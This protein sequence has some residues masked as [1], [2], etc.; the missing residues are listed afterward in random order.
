VWRQEGVASLWKGN[1]ATI[2]HRVP[3][4]A[5]NFAVFEAT[6]EALE[7]HM[8]SDI[9]R[10]LVAGGSAGLVACTAVSRYYPHALGLPPPSPSL[11]HILAKHVMPSNL[12]YRPTQLATGPD[13]QQP[14][15]A[16]AASSLP[17]S[18]PQQLPAADLTATLHVGPGTLGSLLCASAAGFCTSTVTFP[19]DVI[20]KRMQMV[21]AHPG[22]SLTYLQVWSLVYR[23]AGVRGF[24]AG[25]VPEY[26]KVLPGMA[27]AF[28]TYEG[29]RAAFDVGS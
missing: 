20:R 21:R 26:C 7:P 13:S 19:L 18:L 23:Q 29:I 1:L 4:S 2:I 15:A 6:K 3:Y 12:L 10:R 14:H 25:I 9:L 17:A 11:T 28:A 8:E 5:T 24:Y 27:I 22:T 16:L